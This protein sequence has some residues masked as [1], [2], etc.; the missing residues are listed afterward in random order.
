MVAVNGLILTAFV[1]HAQ[2]MNIT[3]LALI[4]IAQIA[5]TTV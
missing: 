3:L 5:K 4:Q 1:V 2:M